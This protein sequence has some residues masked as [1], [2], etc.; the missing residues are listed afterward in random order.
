MLKFFH[1]KRQPLAQVVDEELYEAQCDLIKAEAELERADANAQRLRK[2]VKRLT[3]LM[4]V[5]PSSDNVRSIARK[6]A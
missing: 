2:Q 3:T 4:K 1:N 6:E 5:V